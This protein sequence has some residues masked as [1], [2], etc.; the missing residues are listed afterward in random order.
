MRTMQ[1]WGSL[2][3]LH[4]DVDIERSLLK[5]FGRSGSYCTTY[6]NDKSYKS[7]IYIY[8]IYLYV[9]IFIILS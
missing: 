4:G 8:I 9:Y 7:Y 2:G 6:D 3:E 1:A 5:E